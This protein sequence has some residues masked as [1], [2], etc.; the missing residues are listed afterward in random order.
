MVRL[1]RPAAL[2]AVVLLALAGAAS[3]FVHVLIPG[4]KA[5]G[6]IQ[7]PGEEDRIYFRADAGWIVSFTVKA[8]KGQAL[9]P[10]ITR[11]IDPSQADVLGTAATP[12]ANKKG[13]LVKLR[14]VVP[15]AGTWVLGI[16]GASGTTGNWDLVSKGPA[17]VPLGQSTIS[18]PGA[19]VVH[20]FDADVGT[21]AAIQAKAAAGS[22]LHPSIPR[23]ERPAAAGP[24]DLTAATRKT[25]AK[26]DTLSNLVLGE[27]GTWGVPVT[28]SGGTT[29]AYTLS[30]KIGRKV[31]LDFTVDPPPPPPPPAPTVSG[32]S[33]PTVVVPA[34]GN[35]SEMITVDGTGFVNGAV[36]SISP[37]SGNNGVSSAATTFVSSVALTVTF[38]LA[39]TATPGARDVTVT[40][41]DL[42]AATGLG[43]LTIQPPAST[44]VASV[45][46]AHGPGAGGTRVVVQGNLYSSATAVTFGGV[47][48]RAVNVLDGQTILCTAPPA[49]AVSATAGIAVD[50]VVDNGGGDSATLAGGFTYDADPTPPFVVSTVPAQAATGVARNTLIYVFVLSEPAA[51]S[52]LSSTAGFQIGG[53]PVNDIPGPIASVALG[54]GNRL[55]AVQRNA[56]P[57][58]LLGG[59]GYLSNIPVTVTDMAGHPLDPRPFA[60]APLYQGSFTVHATNNDATAPT[61]AATTPPSGSLAGDPSAPV[62]ITFS[63]PV[64]PTTVAGA[65]SLKQGGSPVSVDV[66]LDPSCTVATL[67]PRVKLG[68]PAT[69]YAVGVATSLR[70]MAGNPLAAP[71][72]GPFTIAA[73]TTPPVA[74]VTV[75]AL[76]QDQNGSGTFVPGTSNGPFP[77]APGAPLAYNAYLPRSGFTIQVDFSDAGGSGPDPAT[78]TFT[79]SAAMGGVASGNDLSSQFTTTALGATWTVDG[80]HALAA[81]TNITFTANLRD[82]A[83]NAATAASLAVDVADITKTITNGAGTASTDRDP[84]NARQSWLLRFD[85]DVWTITAS[86]G[87]PNYLA[88]SHSKPITILSSAVPDGIPDFE[89]DLALIGLNGPQT[90]VN[91]ATVTN[92]SDTGTNAIVKTLVKK[93]VRGFLNQRYGMAFDGTRS[94]DS[95]NVEFLLEGETKSGGGAVAHTGWTSG[96]GFS[97]MTF[98]GDERAVSGVALSIGAAI[99]RAPLDFRNT[100]QDDAS[101]TTASDGSNVGVFATHF[102]R[103][104]IDEP[105]GTPFPATFDPL[106]SLAGRVDSASQTGVPVGSSNDDAV[107]LAGSFVYSSANTVRKARFDLIM[108]AVNRYAMC[109]SLTGAHEMGHAMGLLPDGPPPGGLFGNAHQNNTFIAKSNFTTA[110]HI[111]TLGNNTMAAASSFDDGVAAGSDFTVFEP[112]SLSYLLR[113]FLY[114]H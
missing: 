58:S 92:G 8:R 64:D 52:S 62:V 99:G 47:P 66:D 86:A 68:P 41:P 82:H 6:L 53:T 43:A 33:P 57:P 85:Q 110:N 63:E 104:H 71:Y 4:Q 17:K 12:R 80:A 31:P 13:T 25:T 20:E 40:N 73:D 100:T 54:P 9:L 75:D 77:S 67:T 44:S 65:V 24:L 108:T 5:F 21:V 10:A 90:A 50:V 23:I 84:F 83:G 87:T 56:A 42:Q 16:S 30:L 60:G 15:Q 76:P 46:P 32:A 37:G 74:A 93:A 97:M 106:I 14:L 7:V 61:V 48:A 36:A 51:P 89:Q 98:T 105:D 45:T 96:S 34:S 19:E 109:L 101:N 27:G 113:R 94:A 38:K 39:S 103:V 1:P 29:G 81:G 49:A 28:G 3:G 88:P 78:F 95:V 102:I 18:A 11:L 55:V 114:D 35:Q 72:L 79:C 22:T 107:V 112:L 59:N 70:D 111:D 26:A 91:A 69:V 2:A